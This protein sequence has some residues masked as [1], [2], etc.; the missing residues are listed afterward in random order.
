VA[1]SPI[2]VGFYARI[3]TN[4]QQTLSLQIKAMQEYARK[5]GWQPTIEIK[6]VGSGSINRPKREKLMQ[7]ARKR[8]IDL[9]I[10]WRLDRWG[11][12]LSDLIVTLKE[13]SELGVGFISLTE[14]VDLT[15]PSGRAMV[16]MLAV[17]AEF[18][19]EIRSER[20]RAGIAQ[21]RL[22]GQALGRPK[23]VGLKV[24]QIRK[25]FAQGLSKAEIAR[26]LNIGRT[27]VRRLLASD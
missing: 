8:E 3:S 19:Q 6:E 2:R 13:L 16:G 17:F 14:A 25:L 11:R 27:S 22:A 15:T 23:S 7:A 20:I 26:R 10:V 4:D 21:A 24:K 18:E 1:K 5:R 12:S 9:V